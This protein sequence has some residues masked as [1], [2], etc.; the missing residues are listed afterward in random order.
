MTY[1][2]YEPG[3]EGLTG[4]HS[5]L[6]ADP[7]DPRKASSADSVT[8]FEKAGVPAAKIL[9]GV[10]FY[11]HVWGQVEDRNHGLFQSGRQIPK[12]DIPS[13]EIARALLNQ[14]LDH[15]FVRYWDS[16][17]SV[18]YLY[19]PDLQIFVSYEDAE[20]LAAK[21]AYVK[22]QGLRG[23]MF[24]DYSSDPTGTLLKAIDTAL[25]NSPDQETRSK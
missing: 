9:L 16:A 24:W 7:T 18:P 2:F 15:G 19:S 11:G 4:N 12:S 23:V 8:A 13:G 25:W 10:P 1:D 22:A 5:P 14:D 20:S 3:S 17:A 21:C 6:F